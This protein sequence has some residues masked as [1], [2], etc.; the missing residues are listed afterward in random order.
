M[1]ERGRGEIEKIGMHGDNGERWERCIR[2]FAR[3]LISYY[4]VAV[5][6]RF[7]PISSAR[8][9]GRG[10]REGDIYIYIRVYNGCPGRDHVIGILWSVSNR[11]NYVQ[12]NKVEKLV[13]DVSIWSC[14]LQHCGKLNHVYHVVI[15]IDAYTSLRNLFTAPYPAN[16]PVD[17]DATEAIIIACLNDRRV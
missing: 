9:R 10:T 4:E 8:R 13:I 2:Y 5:L 16:Y 14:S 17:T 1:D 12:W 15:N 6:D 7:R 11:R 3:F